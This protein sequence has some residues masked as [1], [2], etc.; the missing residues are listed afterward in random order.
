MQV[1]S[2]TVEAAKSDVWPRLG[3]IPPAHMHAAWQ[4]QQHHLHL[5]RRARTRA[6]RDAQR[7]GSKGR[8]AAR[9]S[10]SRPGD[11][12]GDDVRHSQDMW[13]GGGGRGGGRRSAL[14]GAGR[15]SVASTDVT[16]GSNQD[17]SSS[18]SSS[19]NS[20]SS[21]S[22]S[23]SDSDVDGGEDADDVAVCM[24]QGLAAGH[25]PVALL[26]A[27]A[28]ACKGFKLGCDVW[29]CGIGTP[30]CTQVCRLPGTSSHAGICT[31]LVSKECG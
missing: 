11:T 29:A 24:Q 20:S 23:S 5:R 10:G 8:A 26:L 3:F 27:A 1:M 17:S 31:G 28:A 2:V 14:H 6:L 12:G 30:T 18:T 13:Q 25:P 7:L 9:S 22:G 21:S 15:C 19:G 16:N 4:Q